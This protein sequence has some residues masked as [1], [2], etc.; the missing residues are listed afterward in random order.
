MSGIPPMAGFFGKLFVFKAAI[1]AELYWLAVIGVVTSVIAA[2]YYLRLIK[3]MFFDQPEDK[4]NDNIPLARHV[5]L[6]L[7]LAVVTLFIFMPSGL[8][9]TMNEAA[10]S[11]FT[12]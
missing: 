8:M 9:E 4:I 5:V 2:F 12:S 1:S 3:V 11:L 10:Q 7:S 6:G